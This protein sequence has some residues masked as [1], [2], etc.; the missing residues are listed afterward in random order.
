MEYQRLQEA[1]RGPAAAAEERREF[2]L[3]LNDDQ[4]SAGGALHGLRHPF[5]NNGCPVNNIIP[6]WNDLVYRQT[7]AARWT[8][9]TPPTTSRSSPAA[10]ARRRAK[11]PVP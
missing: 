5:C 9:C 6:D 3:H 8:C 10:S 7:G 2:V 4:A 11:P 1:L